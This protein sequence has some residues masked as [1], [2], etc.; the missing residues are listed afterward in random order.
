L[1]PKIGKLRY[2]ELW[3]I[4]GL[5]DLNSI[6]ELEYLQY[7]F[8]QA[9]KQVTALPS[10][11]K[12]RSLRRVELMTMKGLQDLSPIAEAPALEELIVDDTRQLAPEAFRPFLGHPTLR[13]ALIGLGSRKKNQEASALLGLPKVEGKF[14]FTSPD[15]A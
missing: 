14:V 10:F 2:L 15:P 8:L 12:L 1:L 13:R 4:R 11:S 6:A 9:L 5:T 3:M 7:L